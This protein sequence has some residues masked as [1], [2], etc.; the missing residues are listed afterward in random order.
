MQIK[1]EVRIWHIK[2]RS[3]NISMSFSLLGLLS[4]VNYIT[5]WWE[6]VMSSK[7]KKRQGKHELWRTS[8]KAQ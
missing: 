4:Y 8:S 2:Q 1:I 6:F 5:C 3:N 7:E